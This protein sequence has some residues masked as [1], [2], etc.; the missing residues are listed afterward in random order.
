MI[1]LYFWL[2]LINLNTEQFENL[3]IVQSC[4]HFWVAFYFYGHFQI[5]Y[6]QIHKL[7]KCSKKY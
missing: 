5:V 1:S 6:F 4:F 7:N 2:S 3:R